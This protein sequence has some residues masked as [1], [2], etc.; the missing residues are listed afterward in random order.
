MMLCLGIASDVLSVACCH[1]LHVHIWI[2][3]QQT[4]IMNVTEQS[5]I[6]SAYM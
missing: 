2:A 5:T 4:T 6:R 1:Q 3:I